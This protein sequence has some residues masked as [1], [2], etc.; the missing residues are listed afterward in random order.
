MAGRIVVGTSSW[1][2]PG[3]VEEW[4]PPGL[5]ARDRLAWYAERFEAVEVNSS[6]YAVPERRTVE[7]WVTQT[8][9]GFT[10]DVKLHRLL[11]RHAADL[12]SL[13]TGVRD[14]ASTND[15]GRVELSDRLQAAMLSETLAAVAPL[16][17]HGKLS[18]FLLQLS[19]AFK[20]KSNALDELEP[21]VEGLA[22]HAVAIEFRH[23]GWVDDRRLEDTLGWLSDHHAAFVCTDSPQGK[24]ITM[25]PPIDAVTRDDLAYFRAHGRNVQ[26]Y[27]SGKT[28]A[29]R[30]A[31]DY[32]PEE[33]QE[34][35]GRADG[36]ASDAEIVRMMFNNNRGADAPKA[37]ERMR[38]LLGQVPA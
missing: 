17:E 22:P 10:F 25:M 2:D 9:D 27:Q 21:I 24:A 36:L 33:L 35:R 28:V 15:R 12:K 31:W 1:A 7:R 11:S 29:E 23:R 32:G 38:E 6:F 34:L 3:F 16:A 26:G 8:P 18:S 4:Y 19:P 5:P 20:P 37:G 13:P 14:L 30:F